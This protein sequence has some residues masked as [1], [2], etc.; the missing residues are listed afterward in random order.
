MY[1]RAISTRLTTF[2]ST[3]MVRS[4]W[5][6]VTYTPGQ[7]ECPQIE[8]IVINVQDWYVSQCEHSYRCSR[9]SHRSD[10][11]WR[12]WRLSQLPWFQQ[13]IKLLPYC[14][15]SL[16]SHSCKWLNFIQSTIGVYILYPLVCCLCHL[17]FFIVCYP[18]MVIWYWHD[19]MLMDNSPH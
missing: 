7:S 18:L 2:G 6:W 9:G 1:I 14:M 16:C 4:I 10:Q 8:V 5:W 17:R 3:A 15:S 11:P 19:A 12:A 13:P